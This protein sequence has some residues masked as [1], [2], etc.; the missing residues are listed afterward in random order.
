MVAFTLFVIVGGTVFESLRVGLRN[1]RVSSQ[2]VYATVLAETKLEETRGQK[3]VETG[4][5]QGEF[6]DVYSWMTQVVVYDQG[7]PSRSGETFSVLPYQINIEVFW[8]EDNRRHAV[9]L[10]SLKLAVRDDGG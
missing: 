6:D 1:T 4:Q 8:E 7:P 5:Q 9:R 3:L 2:Y 10:A